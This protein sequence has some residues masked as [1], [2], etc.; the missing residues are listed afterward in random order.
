MARVRVA[1]WRVWRAAG[2][3]RLGGGRGRS[4]S[5]ARAAAAAGALLL[6]GRLVRYRSRLRRGRTD[7]LGP[8]PVCLLHFHSVLAFHDCRVFTLSLF[9]VP[10]SMCRC[11]FLHGLGPHSPSLPVPCWHHCCRSFHC[12]CCC[13]FDLTRACILDF[14]SPGRRRR[15]VGARICR[16]CT[17]QVPVLPLSLHN[18]IWFERTLNGLHAPLTAAASAGGRETPQSP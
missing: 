16:C 8:S 6:L 1:G 5:R 7:V 15:C 9:V 11:L 13:C 2:A 14:T 18:R 12:C 17:S 3:C 4:S 10:V